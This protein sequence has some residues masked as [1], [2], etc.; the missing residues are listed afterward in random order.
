MVDPAI[1]E[2]S[3]SEHSQAIPSGRPR[4]NVSNEISDLLV[5]PVKD[6]F[7]GMEDRKM[8]NYRAILE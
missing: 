5:T 1:Y 3:G 6:E 8:F 7:T 2:H 4:T